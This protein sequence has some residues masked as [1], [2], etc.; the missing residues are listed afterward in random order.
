[1][2]KNPTN[3]TRQLWAETKFVVELLQIA[4]NKVKI[5]SIVGLKFALGGKLRQS[6]VIE[7]GNKLEKLTQEITSLGKLFN[8]V[9]EVV[10]TK[11]FDTKYYK[12]YSQE[13]YT[14]DYA[15]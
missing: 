15:I 10:I 6:G 7:I 14:A 1:M 3:Y 9:T 12:S 2:T 11:Y 13:S 8:Q 4:K 5:S